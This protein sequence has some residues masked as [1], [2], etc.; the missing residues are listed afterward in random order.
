MGRELRDTMIY[1]ISGGSME[2][3]QIIAEIDNEI[4]RL[5]EAR[6]LL[7]GSSNGTKP[8]SAKRAPLSA[9]ARKRIAEAQKK[10]W[11][12]AKKAAK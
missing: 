10:R 3:K 7:V 11:A 5:R 8:A 4:A 9:E 6:T 12:K 1:L 2:T